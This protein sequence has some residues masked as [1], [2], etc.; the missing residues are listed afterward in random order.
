MMAYIY[1]DGGRAD[2]GFKGQA[3]D[4]GAR[5]MAIA[6]DL[7]Y[8]LAYDELAQANKD[9]GYAKSARNGIHKDVFSK[10]LE[11][12]GW[13]WHPAPK[14]TGRK[15][16]ASDMPEGT[17][18]VRMAKHYACVIDG[19][20]H[21]TF[22]CS[23]KMVYG[24]WAKPSDKTRFNHDEW[25]QLVTK[26]PGLHIDTNTMDVGTCYSVMFNGTAISVHTNLLQVNTWVEYHNLLGLNL[27]EQK[28][29]DCHGAV[30]RMLHEPASAKYWSVFASFY[31]A[32]YCAKLD[33]VQVGEVA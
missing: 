22:D 26:V 6:L 14:F 8:K 28:V 10:V 33:E 24:Y 15:A 12:Q 21:D 3:G 32:M 17:V 31:V 2:A 29:K 25:E 16:Y 11:A 19:V 18:I 4:C 7:T 20:P 27:L 5:A 30:Q 23:H 1:N 13:V 9:A